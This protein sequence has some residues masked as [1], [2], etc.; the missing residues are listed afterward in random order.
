MIVRL[1]RTITENPLVLAATTSRRKFGFIS[2]APPVMSIVLAFVFSAAVKTSCIV[3][4]SI[5]SL[6]AGD[7][8]T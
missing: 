1:V 6:R 3:G 4:Q 8:S 7:D 2:G 5:S